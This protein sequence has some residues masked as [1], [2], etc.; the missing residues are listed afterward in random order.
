MTQQKYRQILERKVRIL[1]SLIVPNQEH[2]ETSITIQNSKLLNK[3]DY[4]LTEILR[5]QTVP[6]GTAG[7]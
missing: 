6:P 3:A 4:L 1:S 2:K 7:Y 5:S